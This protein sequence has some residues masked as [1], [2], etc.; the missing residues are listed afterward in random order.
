MR[1]HQ[2]V[3]NPPPQ[4]PAPPPLMPWRTKFADAGQLLAPFD[5]TLHLPQLWT[6]SNLGDGFFLC[7]PV[8]QTATYLVVQSGLFLAKLEAL[9]FKGIVICLCRPKSFLLESVEIVEGVTVRIIQTLYLG[10]YLSEN[11]L[12]ALKLFFLALYHF[13]CCS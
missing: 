4:A 8:I 13:V 3:T 10:L 6:T 2:T 7:S 9:L 5:V 1:S 11:F 12:D